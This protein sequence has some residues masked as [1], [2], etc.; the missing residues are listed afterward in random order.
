MNSSIFISLASYRDPL[1]LN[2]IQSAL[3]NSSGFNKIK[4]GI[5][6]QDLEKN[7]PDLSNFNNCSTITMHPRD[8]KGAG[9]ARSE[10]MKLYNNEDYYLQIDSHTVFE[11]NWD[12]ICI[13]QLNISKQI[14]NNNKIILSC[15]PQPFYSES[16]QK[17]SIIKNNKVQLPYPTKQKLKL[18]KQNQWTA[19]RVELT[20]KDTPEES[21]TILGGFIFAE[22]DI[23]NEIPYDPEIAFFGEEVCFAM[24]A[25]TRGWDIYSP[26]KIITYHFYLRNGFNKIWK[27]SNI[28][29]NSWKEVEKQSMEK[30]KRVLT[31]QE[32]GTYGYGNI[33]TL[34]DFELF[35]GFDFKNHYLQK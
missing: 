12:L 15:F 33:R 9:F 20:N 25:W 19:E 11:K 29:K 8:A 24:R 28:R 7:I 22:G 21:N 16:N 13:D 10:A 23:V 27:D 1:L 6:I 35:T 14:A 31:G 2:T 34:N 3:D 5:V 18:N 4:F 32:K 30:Q 17:V 26:S